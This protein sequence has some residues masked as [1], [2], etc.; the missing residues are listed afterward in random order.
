MRGTLLMGAVCL[1]AFGPAEATTVERLSFDDLVRK[2]ERIFV[3][4][5]DSVR[6]RAETA[7]EKPPIWT[8][9][10]FRDVTKV[11]GDVA[12]S[13]TISLA[14]GRYGKRALR[15]AGMPRFE[16]GMRYAVFLHGEEGKVCPVLGW[17]QGQF[18][19]VR[20]EA[21]DVVRTAD[22]T[23]IREIR[24]GAVLTVPPDAEKDDGVRLTADELLK[25][26]EVRMRRH[27]AEAR[28]AKARE[29]AEDEEEVR[30]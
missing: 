17:G 28:E 19:V 11:K 25:S 10:K 9:V 24:G 13:V 18:R 23:P 1:I 29:E 21:G 16:E 4:R 3:G 27:A 14:G 6:C 8:D 12:A 22:G 26:V 5:V 20:T 15:F 2:A 7:P 30:K